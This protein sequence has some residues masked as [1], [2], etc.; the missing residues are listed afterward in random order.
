[1]EI[2]ASKI[3]EILLN[4]F[5][6][7]NWWPKDKRYHE[8]NNSDPR[9]EI[10]VGAILTQNTAW[11]NVEKALNNIKAKNLLNINNISNIDNEILPDLIKPSGYFNQK[12]K[13]LKILADYIKENFNGDL[14]VFF[15]RKLQEIRNELLSLNGIGPETADSILLYAGKFP[16]FVVD[17]YTK[18]ICQRLPIKVDITYQ[19]IQN[20][21][22]SELSKEFKKKELN[23]VYNE[24]HAQIVIL[25]KTYC[26]KKPDCINCPLKKNCNFRKQLSK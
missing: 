6:N 2:T 24:L 23:K 15:N 22:Q 1:M 17:A 13:R 4:E 25:G 12:A 19:D 21:F 10:I 16:I 3:Y 20:Y 18:R 26:K 5:G 8:I 7:L 9:F 11:V 14:D